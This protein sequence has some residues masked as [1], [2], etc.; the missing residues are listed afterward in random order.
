MLLQTVKRWKTAAR[1]LCAEPDDPTPPVDAVARARQLGVVVGDNC[2]ILTSPDHAFGSEPYLVSLGN[3]VTVSD[4]VQ[5]ITHDGGVWVFREEFP[6]IDVFGP[7]VVGNNVFLG[8][9][10]AIL[11]GVQIGNDVVVGARSLVTRSI[12]SGVV[13]AGIPARVVRS[14]EEYK[15]RSLAKASHFRNQPFAEKRRRLLEMFGPQIKASQ[16]GDS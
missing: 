3:H 2:R 14:I 5:F 13:A 12:P 7:I 11:P 8:F 4:G 1:R 15:V 16:R 9:G 10:V 6:E